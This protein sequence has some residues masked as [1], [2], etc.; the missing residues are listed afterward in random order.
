MKLTPPKNCILKKVALGLLIPQRCSLSVTGSA[1]PW[2]EI[3][4]QMHPA[5]KHSCP[6]QIKM[7]IGL[8]MQW[9]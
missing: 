3:L 7:L 4:Q 2:E 9:L 6:I 5:A 8:E 1:R